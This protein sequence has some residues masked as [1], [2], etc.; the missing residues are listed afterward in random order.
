[1]STITITIS[2]DVPAGSNVRV[3]Q[4]GGSDRPFVARPD[5]IY[6][7]WD[8]TCAVH[9]EDWKLVPSGTS[10]KTGKPYNAFFACPARDCNE[11][12][13]RQGEDS[14]EPNF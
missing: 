9:G 12:P 11:K 3:S 7:E 5:P 10:K 8:P 2:I 1:M 14:Q 13:A 4:G 6:P